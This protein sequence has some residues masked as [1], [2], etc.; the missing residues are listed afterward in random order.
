MRDSITKLV[1]IAFLGGLI[2]RG[3]RYGFSVTIA[4]GLGLD[5]L[6]IFAFGMVVMKGAGVFA[7]VGLDS[8]ANKYIPIYRGQDDAE[9]LNGTVLLCLL[10][11]LL[12]GTIVA[13]LLYFGRGVIHSTVGVTFDPTTQLF[14]AGI[15]L[16]AVM[17]VGVNA[18]YGLNET[19]YS[20][21]IR[22]FGQSGVGIVLIA[23]GAFIFSDLNALVVGYLASIVIG[24]G[25][26]VVFL[27][28]EDALRFDVQPVFEYREI[29][30]FALPLTFAASIQYLVSWTD[31]LVLGVFVPATPIGRYQAAYQTSVLLLIVLQSANSVFPPL[32]SEL[33]DSGKR[34][35]L[36]RV[37]TA[38]TRWVTYL[39]V[40]G[41]AFVAIYAADILSIFGTD[42]RSAQTALIILAAGQMISA[43]VG[44]TGYLLIMTDYERLTLVNNGLAALLNLVLNVVLIQTYGILGAA[45]ATGISLATMNILRLAEVWYFLEI[46]PYSRRYWKGGIAIAASIVVLFLGK[47]LPISSLPRAIL[48]GAVAL[49]LFGIVIW[50]LGFDDLDAALVEAIK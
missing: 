18:T 15:P 50:R 42:A 39:T 11:P 27:L 17:M 31:I 14:I 20:V 9:R 37:Y 23:I 45:I 24:V 28:R 10:I 40:L 38:V 35:E 8:A 34:A 13:V 46:H 36:N 7:R 1:S 5:A 21:Y 19:K 29:L 2:G 3:F 41:F 49:G 26:A 47:L 4:R 25:L 43:I 44:P 32:A 22:D 30:A 48:A 12:V 33:H 6:G 16:F